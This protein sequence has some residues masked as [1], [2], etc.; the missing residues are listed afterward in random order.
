MKPSHRGRRQYLKGV[1]VSAAGLISVTAGCTDGN[2]SGDGSD[3]TPVGS[4]GGEDLADRL[5]IGTGGGAY[6]EAQEEA[7][8]DTFMDEYPGVEIE[9]KAHPGPPNLV[10]K[11]EAGGGT[12]FDILQVD[13]VFTYPA[14]NNGWIHPLRTENIP[15]M[16]NIIDQLHPDNTHI[17]SSGNED[18]HHVPLDYGG[19]GFAYLEDEVSIEVESWED[20][21]HEEF[22]QNVAFMQWID[23]V[24]ARNASAQ[25][26]DFNEIPME[27]NSEWESITEDIFSRV[28]RENDHVV[29][30]LDSLSAVRNGMVQGNVVGT[31][32]WYGSTASFN[33]ENDDINVRYVVPEEGTDMWVD[34]YQILSTVDERKRR[35]AELF[36]DNMLAIE[37]QRMKAEQIPYATCVEFSDPPS[38]DYANN[39]DIEAI[40]DGRITPWNM[41]VQN[42][43]TDEWNQRFIETTRG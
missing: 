42:T 17:E 38:E 26:I 33:N 1:G 20:T 15:N 7:F 39:P 6:G 28:N 27:K 2:G 4:N 10:S 29:E 32:W 31:L 12:E 9:R 37:N 23:G 41:E 36:I 35:T 30:W 24:V 8:A 19:S 16:D 34:T 13:E 11:L 21:L 3:G 18:I 40:D 22:D 25:G 5:V 14:A 43:H